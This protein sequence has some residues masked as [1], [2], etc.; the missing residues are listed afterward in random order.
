MANERFQSLLLRCCTCVCSSCA[1]KVQNY[2]GDDFSERF[3]RVDGGDDD[4]DDEDE[5]EDGDEEGDGDDDDDDEDRGG[6][7]R[8]LFVLYFFVTPVLVNQRTDM[9]LSL[10]PFLIVCVCVCVCACVYASV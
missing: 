10:G 1:V 8:Y 4:D 7:D 3:R 2:P 6:D 9:L 5:E